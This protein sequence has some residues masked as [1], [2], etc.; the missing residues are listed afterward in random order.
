MPRRG[1]LGVDYFLKLLVGLAQ[2]FF[3]PLLLL[4]CE[5]DRISDLY[6]TL[7]KNATCDRNPSFS[8][9]VRYSED[10]FVC[11]SFAVLFIQAGR[12]CVALFTEVW[13][14]MASELRNI[15]AKI[16]FELN[17]S[18][19]M[20]V[21]HEF[22]SDAHILQTTTLTHK[23]LLIHAILP[24]LHITRKLFILA[25]NVAPKERAVTAWAFIELTDVQGVLY[26]FPKEPVIWVLLPGIVLHFV[27][28][29][30]LDGIMAN[31]ALEYAHGW[32]LLADFWYRIIWRLY[33]L[34]T[35]WTLQEVERDA[36]CAPPMSQKFANATC[37]KNV[38]ALQLKARLIAERTP[39]DL[40]PIK[41][42]YRL[43]RS[44]FN[45]KTGQVLVSLLAFTAT[46]SMA[47]RK[48]C[49]AGPDLANRLE[50]WNVV[51]LGKHHR[52]ELGFLLTIIQATVRLSILSRFNHRFW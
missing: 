2:N 49:L 15:A 12:I 19:S 16:A 28:L 7:T 1:F 47:T 29:E 35:V 38:P 25:V 8:W 30:L 34:L 31:F 36:L 51:R 24:G 40:A 50:V 33:V 41:L 6:F 22:L 43:G 48:L 18:Q 20:L 46:A 17:V 32:E 42:G 21:A 44:A 5:S 4:V 10:A 45:F 27:Q 9:M 13:V 39:A 26:R 11:I 37:M 3:K 14:C 23:L 52:E